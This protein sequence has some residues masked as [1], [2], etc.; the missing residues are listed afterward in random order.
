MIYI[1]TF[2]NSYPYVALSVGIPLS[3]SGREQVDY[4]E[5]TRNCIHLR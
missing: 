1:H 2:L 5:N 3:R 4:I